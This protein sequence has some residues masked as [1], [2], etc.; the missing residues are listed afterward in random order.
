M[1]IASMVVHALFGML[2][3]LFFV[4]IYIKADSKWVVYVDFLLI[5]PSGNIGSI[6]LLDNLFA[7]T[8][9]TTRMISIACLIGAFLLATT[10]LLMVFSIII[11][12]KDKKNVLQISDIILGQSKWIDHYY[13]KRMQEIDLVLDIPKLEEREINVSQREAAISAQETILKEEQDAFEAATKKKPRLK[14]P[15]NRNIV[16]TADF[17]GSMPS[18]IDDMV[19]CINNMNA[20]TD[21]MLTKTPDEIDL[22]AI[23]SYFMGLATYIC[24]D[25]F[26]AQTKEVRI[27]FRTYDRVKD[28]YTKFVAVIGK[29]PVAQEMTFIPYQKDNMISRSFQCKRALIKSINSTHDYPSKNNRIWVDYMTYAF[30]GLEV[31]DKPFLSFGIS[32]KNATRYKNILYFLNYFRLEAFLQDNIERVNEHI[33]I[34]NILYGGSEDA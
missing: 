26:N 7:I 21:A 32:I 17:L 9:K 23:R 24:R 14:L 6:F 18:Y 20:L 5:G 11:T 16:L 31:D 27:H 10:I 22:T 13:E 33:N 19:K 8:S 2:L 15:E 34:A 25:I 1:H 12:G 28:G 3:A 30:Y 4:L 29:K